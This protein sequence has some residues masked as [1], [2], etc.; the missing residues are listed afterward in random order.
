VNNGFD[1][2]T[3]QQLYNL[4]F[5]IGTGD[6][7]ALTADKT[8]CLPPGDPNSDFAYCTVQQFTLVIRAGNR[9]N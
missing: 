7:N 4:T 5:T 3:G 9:V 2:A 1:D 6:A 8:A